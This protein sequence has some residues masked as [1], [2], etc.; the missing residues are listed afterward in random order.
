MKWMRGQR[1]TVVV[2][3]SSP[4]VAKQM[5]V[6]HLRSTIIGDCIARILEFQRHNVIRQNHI[7]DWGTQFGTVVLGI[8][9]LAMRTKRGESA[10]EI[11]AVTR[12]LNASPTSDE[13]IELL[14]AQCKI[15]QKDLSE[16]PDGDLCFETFVHEWKPDFELVLPFYQYVTTIEKSADGIER[17]GLYIVHPR[18]GRRHISSLSRHVAAM[19]QNVVVDNLHRDSQ[20]FR[21]WEKAVR[22]A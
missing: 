22:P 5:H 2:D 16:D 15:H 12:N 10:T 14:E 8:W 13:K 6:G 21:A 7:G 20:E 4:N 17:D 19:L 3:Y 9:H 11:T 1:E 18:W